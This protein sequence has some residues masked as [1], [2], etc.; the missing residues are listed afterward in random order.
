MHIKSLLRI[1]SSLILKKKFLVKR[2]YC[3]MLEHIRVIENVYN[4]SMFIITL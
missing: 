4:L 1:A 3:M 2:F